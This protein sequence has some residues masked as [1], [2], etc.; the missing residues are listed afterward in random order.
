MVVVV[1]LVL[2]VV[3]VVVVVTVVDVTRSVS[4]LVGA[5]RRLAIADFQMLVLDFQIR[6]ILS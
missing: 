4:V 5:N 1:M 3:V 2:V 6:G